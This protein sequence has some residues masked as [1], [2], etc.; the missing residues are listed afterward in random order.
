MSFKINRLL[1]AFAAAGLLAACSQ[2]ATTAS[3]REPAPDTACALDGMVLLDFPGPKAQ[4][5]YAEGKADYYCDLMELFTVMLA[6]EHKRRIAGVFVQ[7]MGKTSWDKPSGHWI[8]AKD[9]LY[10]VGSK[11]QG[12]MGPTFGAFS[13]AAQAD[14]FAKAEGGKVLPYGQITVAMLD[15]G[16]AAGDMRH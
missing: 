13:D 11:K 2:Q 10:V 9:A 16:H 14:A 6:P 12:S 3:A 15:T 8:A 4:I 7:D 5:Q 1:A